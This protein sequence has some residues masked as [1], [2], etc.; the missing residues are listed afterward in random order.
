MLRRELVAKLDELG[1]DV[2]L[3][4]PQGLRK[5][6]PDRVGVI[7]A[8]VSLVLEDVRLRERLRQAVAPVVEEIKTRETE[9]AAR[10]QRSQGKRGRPPGIKL[11][12]VDGKRKAIRA[13]RE[14]DGSPKVTEPDVVVRSLSSRRRRG[15]STG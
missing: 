4:A 3:M 2:G 8:A 13:T 7:D 1:E 11:V 10:R 12:E 14:G 6:L 5:G 15:R 9:K